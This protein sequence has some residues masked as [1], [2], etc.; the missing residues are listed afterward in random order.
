[1]LEIENVRE[2]ATDLIRKGDWEVFDLQSP[3]SF[4]DNSVQFITSSVGRSILSDL[5]RI[6]ERRI[7]IR[8]LCL[9]TP[10]LSHLKARLMTIVDVWNI[11]G[12][13][14]LGHRN[15]LSN[16]QPNPIF[17]CLQLSLT[18]FSFSL[19]NL[20]TA[21]PFLVPQ[22]QPSLWKFSHCSSQTFDLSSLNRYFLSK[23]SSLIFLMMSDCPLTQSCTRGLDNVFIQTS[24]STLSF[25]L[26]N[27]SFL[28]SSEAGHQI[29][30]SL[31]FA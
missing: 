25:F 8:F 28:G 10:C 30:P 18:L 7:R 17:E 20:L 14:S 4:T 19:Q 23:S 29:H 22:N 3:S 31:S 9:T 11:S 6:C 15:F 26:S 5:S 27:S 12:T 13:F 16:F 1:M 2:V 21:F 24:A